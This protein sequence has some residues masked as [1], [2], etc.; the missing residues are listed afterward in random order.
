MND[1][2]QGFNNNQT[3]GFFK[4]ELIIAPYT[5]SGKFRVRILRPWELS[6]ILKA[7]PKKEYQTMFEFL[8]YTGMRYIEAQLVKDRYDLFDG[9]NIH[10]IPTIIRKPKCTIKDRYINLNPVAQRVAEDYFKLNVSLPHNNTWV[11]NLK[12][13]ALNGNIDPSFLSVKTTRKTWESYLMTVYP[14]LRDKIFINMGHTDLVALKDY[15][16]LPFSQKNKENMMK[17]VAGW[18]A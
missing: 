13:W 18:D 15:V 16:N 6:Q 4:N 17:Y 8:F 1:I 7:I 10:L 11:Q 2:T 5:H 12:R 9:E 3:Q 14:H